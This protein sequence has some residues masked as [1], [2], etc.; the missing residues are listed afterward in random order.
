MQVHIQNANTQRF[1]H[2]VSVLNSGE[3]G[4]LRRHSRPED[5]RFCVFKTL[6]YL[7]DNKMLKP[8]KDAEGLKI[9][10]KCIKLSR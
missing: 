9:Y 5:L 7:F 4:W 8:K 1:C 2:V 10:T 6:L 3:C